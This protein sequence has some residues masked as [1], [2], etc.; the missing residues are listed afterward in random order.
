[1]SSIQSTIKR[2]DGPPRRPHRR[3]ALR[4][5]KG[6]QTSAELLILALPAILVLFVVC[7]LPMGGVF[8]AFKD[9]QLAKGIFGGNWVGFQNFRFL[10]ESQDAFR[11]TRNTLGMNSLF[12]TLTIGSALVVA[13]MLYDVGKSQVRIFQTVFFFPYFLSWVVIGYIAFIFLNSKYG[14]I[15]GLLATLG[16]KPI[17]FYTTPVYWPFILTI[18]YVWKNLGYTAIIFYTGL[19]SIDTELFE[20]AAIDGASKVQLKTRIALP[21]LSPLIV[22][23]SLLNI[24]KIFYS[25]FGLFFFVP[26]NIGLLYPAT[27]V[28]D[29][30][31]FRAL[32][33][34][35]DIGMAAAAGLYQS[36]VGFALVLVCN[37]V[38]RRVSPENAI[39]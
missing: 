10:F 36:L 27:D 22:I 33:V 32:R 31:V 5:T 3:P 38:I 17:D 34:T 6:F 37:W 4:A 1:M 18:A 30:Y 24:G 8:L 14:V 29:T 39:R 9:V 19:L 35:G 2:G 15:H 25:D 16:A 26:R 23:L 21:L 7:Y 11:I 28:I 13:F 20:A 12:I